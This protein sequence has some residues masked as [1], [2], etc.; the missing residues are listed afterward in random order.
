MDTAAH[1]LIAAHPP[2]MDAADER[3][4]EGLY[5]EHFDFVW[6]S[7]RRFG[8]HP[9]LVE[10]AAQDTFIVV[11]RRLSALRPDAS[12]KAFLF[13][14]AF[15]VALD[16]KRTARRKRV[17]C[18]DAESAASAADSPFEC[19]ARAQAVGVL[20]RFLASIDDG[21]RAV[22]ILAELEQMTAPEI[23][24]ALSINQNTVYSRLRVARERF[25]EFVEAGGIQHG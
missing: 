16:Y 25:V 12:A 3:S 17:S 14:I 10:D 21:K 1:R 18:L 8:V 13:G 9:S 6:R 11:H 15:R 23:S 7:L 20:E 4:F 2:K 22:F 24:E 19:T 5:Q